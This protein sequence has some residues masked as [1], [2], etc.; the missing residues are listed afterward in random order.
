[1]KMNHIYLVEVRL[2]WPPVGGASS[3]KRNSNLGREVS[4]SHNSMSFFFH[5]LRDTWKLQTY[6]KFQE[7]AS[8]HVILFFRSSEL[9]NV[10]KDN[11][12]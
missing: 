9:R 7:H 8:L 4:V 3:A 11:S 1:M 5:R 10:A 6:S 12:V 2:K